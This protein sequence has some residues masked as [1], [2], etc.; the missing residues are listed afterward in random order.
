MDDL[1]TSPEK[2]LENADGLEHGDRRTAP[3]VDRLSRFGALGCGEQGRDHIVDIREVADLLAASV[4]GYRATGEDRFDEGAKGHVG[5]LPGT[6]DG[7]ESQ[8]HDVQAE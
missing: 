6:V 1:S 8:R 4:H 2:T 5:P 3:D 7:E